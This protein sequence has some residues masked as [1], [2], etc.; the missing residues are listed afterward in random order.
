MP[1]LMD[2]LRSAVGMSD[3]LPAVAA[4][5]VDL[6]QQARAGDIVGGASD[7]GVRITDP[8]ERSTLTGTYPSPVV[9]DVIGAA[10]AHGVDP[11]TALA[12]GLQ[13]TGL[14]TAGGGDAF[15]MNPLHRNVAGAATVA[16]RDLVTPLMAGDTEGR[17][18]DA[19]MF[20]A[21]MNAL[22]DAMNEFNRVRALHANSP[23]VHQIQAYNGLGRPRLAAVGPMYGTSRSRDLPT[24]FY[25]Q[26]VQDIREN[27]VAPSSSLQTLIRRTMP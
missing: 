13:E 19:L 26:R 27:V 11:R 9:T 7:P 18:S 8:R 25:G 20:N 24:D 16:G 6:P 4:P 21:R 14:G 23:E 15:A 12:M 1:T 3:D 17:H 2:R 10:R 22:D 5:P